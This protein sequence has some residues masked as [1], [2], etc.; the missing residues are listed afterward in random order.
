MKRVTRDY[1]PLYMAFVFCQSNLS[2]A[3]PI[4]RIRFLT[5]SLRTSQL[6]RQHSNS[7]VFEV[8]QKFPLS[9]D[10][11]PILEERLRILG[12][13]QI[14]TKELTDWYFDNVCS[15]LVQQDCWLRYREDENQGEW[16]LKKGVRGQYNGANTS[17]VY[18]EIEGAKALNAAVD[19]LAKVERK[20]DVPLPFEFAGFAPFHIPK[21]LE[22][23][24][25][26]QLHP[27]ARILTKRASWVSTD[28]CNMM[29]LAL[30]VDLDIT[31]FGYA[32]GE[33]E[34]MIKDR[35]DVPRARAAINGLVKRLKPVGTHSTIAI[36][37][38][39]YYLQ[40]RQPELYQMCI[41]RGIVKEPAAE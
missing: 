13:E 27:F 28:Q 5:R 2:I 15:D 14:T 41:E 19:L 24:S 10:S 7:D 35:R 33:V 29:F 40:S 25:L 36:G 18:E 1:I 9:L 6:P 31:D 20:A 17:T 23:I 21:L 37:K 22:E 26:L 12:F 11:L 8:E 39:E 16:Q 3:L 32:V 34:A 30:T 4:S 38:L